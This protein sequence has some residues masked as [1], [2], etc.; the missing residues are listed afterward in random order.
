MQQITEK[1]PQFE[2]QM[3]GFFYD[4]F[5]SVGVSMVATVAMERLRQ[6][7]AKMAATIE[8]AAER[9]A[10]QVIQKLQK[11][12]AEGF[13]QV[14]KKLNDLNERLTAIESQFNTPSQGSE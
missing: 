12:V 5:R 2:E 1:A 11:P 13:D 9:K 4:A 14:E 8:W 7:G 10:I 3:A 6:V